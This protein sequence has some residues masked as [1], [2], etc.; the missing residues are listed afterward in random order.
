MYYYASFNALSSKNSFTNSDQSKKE[1]LKEDLEQLK[2]SLQGLVDFIGKFSYTISKR[3]IDSLKTL[4]ISLDDASSTKLE[5]SL[6][7]LNTVRERL[8]RIVEGLEKNNL[9]KECDPTLIDDLIKIY[10]TNL[11]ET[12]S[13]KTLFYIKEVLYP[14]LVKSQNNPELKVLIG[15][16]NT[17]QDSLKNLVKWQMLQYANE[18]GITDDEFPKLIASIEN[19]ASKVIDVINGLDDAESYEKVGKFIADIGNLN[20]NPISKKIANSLI[21]VNDKYLSVEKEKNK[22]NI[23]VESAFSDIYKDYA[24]RGSKWISPYLTVGINYNIADRKAVN[25][26]TFTLM[27]SVMGVQVL[28]TLVTSRRQSTGFIGEKLGLK[29]KIVDWA[30]RSTYN[31]NVVESGSDFRKHIKRTR[32]PFINDLYALAYG[33]GLLY[34][35]DAIN[36]DGSF[37]SPLIGF[38]LG[39]SFFNNLDLNANYTFPTENNFTKGFFNISFDIRLTEYLSELRKKRREKTFYE[40]KNEG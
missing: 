32:K 28:D 31:K 3:E 4:S 6:K 7:N 8:R 10:N 25:D 38:G 27:K 16:V 29:V 11:A 12:S 21:N 13:N 40:E 35:L 1:N 26:T 36:T 5:T 33:S 18:I 2:I 22:V 23:D 9:C 14:K 30:K 17:Y 24:E 37:N 20:E 39:A 34:Q 19:Y 15:E